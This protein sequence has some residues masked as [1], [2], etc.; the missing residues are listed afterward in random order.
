MS[1]ALCRRFPPAFP[2]ARGEAGVFVSYRRDAGY[3]LLE[4]PQKKVADV[5]A[6][7]L[8]AN[9]DTKNA[10]E[11]LFLMLQLNQEEGMTFLFSTHDQRVI[12]L[13]DGK[14]ARD[15]TGNGN[16]CPIILVRVRSPLDEPEVPDSTVAHLRSQVRGESEITAYPLGVAMRRC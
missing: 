16:G 3:R 12:T 4:R 5:A 7:W 11:L 2:Q 13:E 9:P 14:V 15:E 6:D 1:P 10:L 8:T